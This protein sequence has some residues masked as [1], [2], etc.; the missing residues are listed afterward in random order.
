MLR[1]DASLEPSALNLVVCERQSESFSVILLERTKVMMELLL[2]VHCLHLIEPKYIILA[3]LLCVLVELLDV[4]WSFL[5]RD[6]KN[7][8]SLF[9][10]LSKPVERR[11]EVPQVQ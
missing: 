2:L 6:D 11:S 1:L 7:S 8:H 5:L 3:F 9:W 4:L 10:L